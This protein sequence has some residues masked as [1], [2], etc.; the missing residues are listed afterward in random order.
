MTSAWF[1]HG[2]LGTAGAPAPSIIER[3]RLGNVGGIWRCV[4]AGVGSGFGF[5]VRIGERRPR[6][7]RDR[8][9]VGPVAGRGAGTTAEISISEA[10]ISPVEF[11]PAPLPEVDRL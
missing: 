6:R 2:C 5:R 7:R 1:A 9:P 4:G 11:A 3:G 10:E 8:G